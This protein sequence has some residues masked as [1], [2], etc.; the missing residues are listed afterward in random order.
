MRW[1]GNVRDGASRHFFTHR[2][3]G[4]ARDATRQAMCSK[5][6]SWCRENKVVVRGN[7]GM[8]SLYSCMVCCSGCACR[9]VDALLVVVT[10]RPSLSVCAQK[11]P[12]CRRYLCKKKIDRVKIQDARAFSVAH[13]FG[14]KSSGQYRGC[15]LRTSSERYLLLR[16]SGTHI[17]TQG[18]NT[19][20]EKR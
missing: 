5:P 2:S 7:S 1:Y 6:F 9:C 19:T 17:Y 14:R 3:N 4:S 15:L 13:V 18:L 11:L 12:S 16:T 10:G 20:S 8:R